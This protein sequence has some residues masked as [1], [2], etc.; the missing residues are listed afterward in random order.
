[1][2]SIRKFVYAG[3][4]AFTAMNFVPAVASAQEMAHGKFTLKHEVLWAN[5]IVPAGDYRFSVASA[6]PSGLLTL[7][8]VS[9]ASGGFMFL[10]HDTDQAKP[11]D[12]NRLV[13]ETTAEGSYVKAM[14]LPEFGVT[15]NFMAPTRAAEK[16][17]A[18]TPTGTTVAAAR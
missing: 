5:A 2:T 7:T 9:G 15:L 1:M 11:Q 17:V 13:L 6:G 12:L 4:L 3:L 16:Q 14:H 18:K 10:V 8:K